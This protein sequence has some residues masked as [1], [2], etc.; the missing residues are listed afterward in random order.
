MEESKINIKSVIPIFRIFDVDKA[1]EFYL[2]FLDFQIDW[3]HRYSDDLPMYMQ[4]SYGACKIH[5][6]EHHGDCLPGAS[7]RI[8]VD[9]VVELH[10]KLSSK[11][12]K[13]CR[14]GLESTQWNSKETQVKDP[15]GNRLV[16]Y[17]YNC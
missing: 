9:N 2:Q 7:I 1:K 4:I 12:Y 13:Y 6:S 5:L 14:P 16:F 15:F 10:S 8:E 11:Q 17:Q 3:E